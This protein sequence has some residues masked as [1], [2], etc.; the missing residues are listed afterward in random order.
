MNQYLSSDVTY[1][2]ELKEW[3]DTFSEALDAAGRELDEVRSS[4]MNQIEVRYQCSQGKYKQYRALTRIRTA[5]RSCTLLGIQPATPH[6][7]SRHQQGLQRA[8]E[9]TRGLA[10]S[11]PVIQE[12]DTCP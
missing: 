11:A 10:A 2:Q 3:R 1:R 7:M 8:M 12:H 9:A 4:I 6:S 5:A